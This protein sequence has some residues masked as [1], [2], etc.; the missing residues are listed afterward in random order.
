MREGSVQ[1]LAL[2]GFLGFFFVALWV[3]LRLVLLWRRTRELPELLIG[4]GVLGIGPVGFGLNLV[5]AATA[6]DPGMPSVIAALS[7]LAVALGATA[8]Y[9][10]NWRIYHTESRIAA[11]VAA[12]GIALLGVGWTGDALTTGFA[13]ASWMRPGWVLV[14]QLAQVGA[15]LWGAGEALGWWRRMQRRRAIGL[16]D[17]LVANR[18][19]LWGLGA[20]A[21]GVGSLIGTVFGLVLARPLNQLPVLTLVLSLHGLVAAI[22]LW[23]AFVPP[24]WYRHWVR[25]TTEKK[26][27]A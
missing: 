25:G 12:C 4:I 5:A 11:T 16:A 1:I 2:P 6:V 18:F 19:L 22:A 27:P 15:L 13:P 8:K 17:P 20:G 21:A 3:G 7:A 9:V 24:V 10:F 26:A 23:L 14:R